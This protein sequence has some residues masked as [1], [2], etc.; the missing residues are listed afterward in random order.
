MREKF[1]TLIP[2]ITGFKKPVRLQ[3][4]GVKEAI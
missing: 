3:S 1:I 4:G 2:G